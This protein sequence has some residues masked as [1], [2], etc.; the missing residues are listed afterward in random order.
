MGQDFVKFSPGSF[1]LELSH[2]LLGLDQQER[3][4][5][6]LRSSS[7]RLRAGG[8]GNETD[9]GKGSELSGGSAHEQ[10]DHMLSAVSSSGPH[11]DMLHAKSIAR[12]AAGRVGARGGMG[13][14]DSLQ[15][16]SLFFMKGVMDECTHIAN[17]SGGLT[18]GGMARA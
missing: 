9:S 11:I 12:A 8:G 14:R 18:V 15:R 5:M 6:G 17:F 10:L 16:Q 13:Q 2:E 3:Q 4:H 1:D 7:L